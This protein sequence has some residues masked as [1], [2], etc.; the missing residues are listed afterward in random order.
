L[1]WTDRQTNRQAH[2]I[3]CGAPLYVLCPK[4]FI[5]SYNPSVIGIPPY[6]MWYNIATE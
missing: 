6:E 4:S 5:K 3:P 1:R 2:T